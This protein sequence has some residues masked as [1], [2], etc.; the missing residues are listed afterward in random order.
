MIVTKFIKEGPDKKGLTHIILVDED[1]EAKTR[2]VKKFIC[3]VQKQETE[4]E[5]QMVAD[6]LLDNLNTD[7]AIKQSKLGPHEAKYANGTPV[8]VNNQFMAIVFSSYNMFTNKRN[9]IYKVIA[10]AY[11]IIHRVRNKN[12]QDFEVETDKRLYDEDYNSLLYE[13]DQVCL[14]ECSEDEL[15]AY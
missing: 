12:Y 6:L 10:D 1:Q 15:R 11:E 14:I 4:E 9:V 7:L 3:E 5:T 2:T 8:I 13:T